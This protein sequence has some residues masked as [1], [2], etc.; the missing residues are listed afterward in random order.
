MLS[1]KNVNPILKENNVNQDGRVDKVLDKP[2]RY[3]L[4]LRI[5]TFLVSSSLFQQC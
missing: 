5:A 4:L 1:W 2:L 3:L